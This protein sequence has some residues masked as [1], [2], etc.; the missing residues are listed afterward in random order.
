MAENKLHTQSDA[1]QDSG[2]DPLVRWSLVG[3]VLIV[4]VIIAA[5]PLFFRGISDSVETTGSAGASSAATPSSSVSVTTRPDCPAQGVAGVNLDCLGGNLGQTSAD[6]DVDKE[7]TL[8]NLWAWWCEP[9]RAELPILEQ[10]SHTYPQY[11]VVGVHADAN[12]AA[13]ADMLTQLG[14]TLPSYQDSDNRCAGTLGLPSVVPITLLVHDG[15]IISTFTT[16]FNSV[17]ELAAA[18]ASA[19]DG[20]DGDGGDAQ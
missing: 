20:A 14:V 3:I 13:G 17:Q 9:C 4:A 5:F 19:R 10:F 11:Q 6:S 7:A 2:L 15:R 12:A 1:Q 18:V 16:P 8:V